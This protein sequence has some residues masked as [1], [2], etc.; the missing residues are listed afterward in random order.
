MTLCNA[1]KNYVR[2]E[3][4]SAAKHLFTV[5]FTLARFKHL[6]ILIGTL[7]SITAFNVS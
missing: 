6:I 5:F 4:T 2:K 1:R 3:F 7:I